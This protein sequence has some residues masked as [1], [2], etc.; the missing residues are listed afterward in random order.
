[1][2]VVDKMG[3]LSIRSDLVDQPKVDARL[4]AEE[5]STKSKGSDAKAKGDP[6]DKADSRSSPRGRAKRD[7]TKEKGAGP[8]T[9][10]PAQPR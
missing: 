10:S 4:P 6:V 1:M 5:P 9:R 8:T 7:A 3:N 2:L